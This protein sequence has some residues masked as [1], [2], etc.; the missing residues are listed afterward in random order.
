MFVPFFEQHNNHC[1]VAVRVRMAGSSIRRFALWRFLLGNEETC[2]G[3]HG[4]RVDT[5]GSSKK[6]RVG[7]RDK[8]Q[9][10]FSMIGLDSA[11]SLLLIVVAIMTGLFTI[12]AAVP[13]VSSFSRE[14]KYLNNEIERTSGK[15][16]MRWKRQRRRLWLSLL[17]FVKY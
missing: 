3:C 8:E 6:P 17:P 16:R 4:S 10:V 5:Q 11:T 1:V 12:V 9:V 14:L 15:E 7:V 13:F 2:V